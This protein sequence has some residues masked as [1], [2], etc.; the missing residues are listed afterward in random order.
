MARFIA[1]LIVLR[2]VTSSQNLRGAYRV[3]LPLLTNHFRIMTQAD[4]NFLQALGESH[5]QVIAADCKRR[6]LSREVY[7]KRVS[8]SEKR[9]NKILREMMCR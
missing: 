9:A 6:K 8:Q 7:N 2:A 3:L 5:E 1:A 4:V